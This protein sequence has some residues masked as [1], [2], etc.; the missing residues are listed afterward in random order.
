MCF[1]VVGKFTA[2]VGVRRLFQT[3]FQQN[4]G[5][6]WVAHPGSECRPDPV[7]IRSE[8]VPRGFPAFLHQ[9]LLFNPVIVPEF[10]FFK[11]VTL[12]GEGG[13]VVPG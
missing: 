10:V 3:F 9:T 6:P 7:Q 2:S 8:H 4:M 1:C 5:V 12:G 13:W 11:F